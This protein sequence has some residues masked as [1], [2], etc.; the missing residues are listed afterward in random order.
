VWGGMVSNISY[1]QRQQIPFKAFVPSHQTHDKIFKKTV[2][3]MLTTVRTS[4]FTKA[5]TI[6]KEGSRDVGTKFQEIGC[7]LQE[8]MDRSMYTGQ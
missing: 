5:T 8:I 6:S 2:I 3:I 1:I 4:Y 7:T